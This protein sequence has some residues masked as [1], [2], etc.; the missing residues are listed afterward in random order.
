[1]IDQHQ[2]RLYQVVVSNYH[3]I[4][5]KTVPRSGN[6]HLVLTKYCFGALVSSSYIYIQ[7]KHFYIIFWQ[8][9]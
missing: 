2:E 8:M 7:I 9:S 1:M 3:T 6:E 4:T 5:T